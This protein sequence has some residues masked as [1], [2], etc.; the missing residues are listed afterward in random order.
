MRIGEVLFTC[1]LLTTL[2]FVACEKREFPIQL[3]APGLAQHASVNMGETYDD[4]LYFDFE[5]GQVV[6]TSPVVAWDLAFE[7]EAFSNHVFINGGKNVFI[8]NTHATDPALVTSAAGITSDHWLSDASCGLPDSTAVGNWLDNNGHSKGEVYILKVNA[9]TF[10]KFIIDSVSQQGYSLRY[11]DLKALSLNQIYLPK[12]STC[13]Y[14]YFSF[15]NGGSIVT[16]EPPKDSWDIVFT[17][18]RIVYAALNN[19]PYVV[20]GVLTNPNNTVTQ[21]DSTSG[22]SNI[23]YNATLLQKPFSNARD[24]VGFDWKKYDFNTGKYKTDTMKCYV[25]R[26]RRGHYWKLRFVDF[27]NNQ[28]LKGAPTFEFSQI[29]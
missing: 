23:Q 6:K 8:Y 26:N 14:T 27:Y 1:A 28:G 9:Q 13:S 17:R 10:W 3:P 20:S 18:Y 29:Q 2:S 16:P 5:T 22:F 21:A 25:I 7:T 12:S 19:F 15:D 24:V 4:Q 11:G